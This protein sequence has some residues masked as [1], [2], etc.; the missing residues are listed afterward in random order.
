MFYNICMVHSVNSSLKN[1][2]L[3]VMR[4]VAIIAVV[5]VHVVHSSNRF[6][7]NNGGTTNEI[8]TKICSNGAWG[9]ELF[10]LIS[11]WLLA[12]VYHVSGDRLGVSYFY[13]RLARIFPLWTFFL[14]L[15]V[16]RYLLNFNGT[17]SYLLPQQVDNFDLFL[18]V[19]ST[20]TFT[21]WFSANLWNS[22][23]PGGWTIQVEVAHYLVFPLIRNRSFNVVLVWLGFI[24]I[25]TLLIPRLLS[26]RILNFDGVLN[27]WLRLNFYS[28]F[29]YFLIGVFSHFFWGGYK[30]TRDV[31]QVFKN[32]HL[33][34]FILLFYFLTWLSLPLAY[35]HHGQVGTLFFVLLYIFISLIIFKTF[36]LKKTFISFG[37]YSY[38]VYFFHF[39]VLEF[40]NDRLGNL[41]LNLNFAFSYIVSFLLYLCLVVILSYVFAIPS[42]KYIERPFINWA[43][44]RKSDS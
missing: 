3:D 9:V 44:S 34:I 8:F 37:R 31:S 26:L 39:L 6:T 29:G 41:Y 16:I 14:F 12:S 27:A 40:L 4:G 33:N 20:L 1:E 2:F 24:N 30:K 42:E 21:L 5:V 18:I 28:T 23:I 13:R 32:L 11:G 38:F 36:L 25:F 15:Q 7:T 17:I 35:S 22:V 10:F 19:A 43:R